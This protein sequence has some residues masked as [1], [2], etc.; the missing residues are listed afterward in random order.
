MIAG[1]AIIKLKAGVADL[2]PIPNGQLL[3]SATREIGKI[4]ISVI[5]PAIQFCIKWLNATTAA[6]LLSNK[7]CVR[8]TLLAS[9]GPNS[10]SPRMSAVV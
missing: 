10:T 5:A 8:A 6:T 2:H 3:K 1:G 9:P 7:C 4:D